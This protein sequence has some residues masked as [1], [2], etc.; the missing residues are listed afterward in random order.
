MFKFLN[1]VLSLKVKLI[2]FFSVILIIPITIIGFLAYSTAKDSIEKETLNGFEEKIKI[3]NMV[4][5][6]LLES[7][8]KDI[9][10][11]S[12]GIT[13]DMYQK[14]NISDLRKRMAEY[15]SN[16][17]EVQS[18]FIGTEDGKFI[19]E[20]QRDI[21]RDD[22][23]R[24]RD[25]YKDTMEKKGEVVIT[26]PYISLDNNKLVVSITKT[27]NDGS[28]VMGIDI[29][30]D[31]LQSLMKEV[32]VGKNGY[33]FLLDRNGQVLSHPT[34]ELGTIPNNEFFKKLYGNNQGTFK[35]SYDGKQKIMSYY[36]NELSGWKIAGTIENSEIEKAV[37]PIFRHTVIVNIVAVIFGALLVYIAVDSVI[38]PIRR[39]KE[40]AVKIS[41][42]NLTEKIDIN[43]K[44]EIGLLA[45]AFN[46]MREHLINLVKEIEISSEQVSSSSEQ[47]S[48][49][50]AQSIHTAEQVSNSIQEVANN[51][52]KQTNIVE[53]TVQSLKEFSEGVT[54]IAASSQEVTALAEQVSKKAEEGGLAVNDTV[55]QMYSID[56]SVAESNKMIKSLFDLSKEVDSILDVITGIADQ[57]NLLALNAA[58]EAAR[59]G[60]HGKGFAVVA[61]EVRKLAEQSQES[62][63]EVINIIHRIQSNI[64]NTVNIMDQVNETVKIGVNVSKDTITKF[65]E[66]LESTKQVPLKMSEVSATAQEMSAAIHE[67]TET[68]NEIAIVAQ[69]N[70][71]ASEEVAASSEEQLASM[72]QISASAQALAERALELKDLI[73]KFK[74]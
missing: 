6:N 54:N 32:T 14:D 68:A 16:H 29:S 65:N 42:G 18:V 41:K 48:A 15:N 72:E 69:G 35:Y 63:K 2:I 21:G 51:A 39:I 56:Q 11:L 8:S 12:S 17:S 46:E 45:S 34:I 1:K 67:I 58:I 37:N 57:T 61:D 47:L 36:T 62:A 19:Q 66:I 28:G 23:P 44:D 31:D 22:D 55:Q 59:A 52:E 7:K 49:S 10:Y 9:E 25:W 64:E 40:N 73:E 26:D 20:P 43:S 27:L 30:L 74:Y 4:I 50:A 71:A 5:N 53:K 38:K 13:K 70:A 3:V 24:K 33:A 60:E